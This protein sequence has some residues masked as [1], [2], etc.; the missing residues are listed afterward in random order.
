LLQLHL[1]QEIFEHVNGLCIATCWKFCR[2]FEE[3]MGV[4][5]VENPAGVDTW[6]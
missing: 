2:R 1:R 4:D 3:C 6:A 5:D